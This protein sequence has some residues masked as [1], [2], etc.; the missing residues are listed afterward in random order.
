MP[1]KS[2]EPRSSD[3]RVAGNQ[4]PE[5]YQRLGNFQSALSPRPAQRARRAERS[6]DIPGAQCCFSLRIDTRGFF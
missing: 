1:G 4:N 6:L 5:A 3:S 2:Q